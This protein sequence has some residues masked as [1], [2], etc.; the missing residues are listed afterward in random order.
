MKISFKTKININIEMM[1]NMLKFLLKERKMLLL[2]IE[3]YKG[4]NKLG[5]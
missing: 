1:N 5:N 3:F 4:E 2:E